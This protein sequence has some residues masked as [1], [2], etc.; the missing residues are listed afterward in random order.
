[1]TTN[2]SEEGDMM[3]TITGLSRSANIKWLITVVLTVICLVIPEQGIYTH[4][5]KLFL[6]VTVFSLALMAFEI[7]PALFIAFVMPVSWM[8]LNLAPASGV[9]K[10][11]GFW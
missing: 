10:K 11:K 3:S 7:V 6:A 4:E 2:Y 5:V 9:K 8:F 1:M